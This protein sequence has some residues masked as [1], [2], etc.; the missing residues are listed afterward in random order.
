MVW[1]ADPGLIIMNIP[2]G[3]E[4]TLTV[5]MSV[6]AASTEK[7]NINMAGQML[8]TTCTTL[9][10]HYGMSQTVHISQ[11]L[12]CIQTVLVH[13][14]SSHSNMNRHNLN[15]I[16]WN[17]TGI[18]SSSPYLCNTLNL[19]SIDICGISE[20]WLYEKDLNFLNEIDNNYISYAVSDNDLKYPGKRRVGKGGVAILWHKKTFKKS[21]SV[22]NRR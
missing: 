18:M 17:A 3:S 8:T 1:Y 22:I 4:Q 15:V 7:H 2:K 9:S 10:R 16:S 20:H 13:W 5:R 12:V 6:V 14:I 11:F 21:V 19:K